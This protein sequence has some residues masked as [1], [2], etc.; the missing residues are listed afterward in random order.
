M[1]SRRWVNQSQPQTL[2]SASLLLYINAAFALLTLLQ[3]SGHRLTN[4]GIFTFVMRIPAGAAAGWGIANERRWGYGLGL[5]VAFAPF[6]LGLVFAGNIFAD[7]LLAVLFELVLV[8]LLLHP[9]S[10]EYA[11]IY[12][13]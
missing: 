3:L 8:A 11:R 4:Y 12:F 5:A 9:Q 7:D 1:E 13:K 10:R 6:V 2:F